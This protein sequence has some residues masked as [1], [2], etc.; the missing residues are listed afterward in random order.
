MMLE[1]ATTGAYFTSN[2]MGI[3]NAVTCVVK[4]ERHDQPATGGDPE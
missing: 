3:G 4:R 1:L 2:P